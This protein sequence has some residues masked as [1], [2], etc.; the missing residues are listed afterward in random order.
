MSP[1]GYEVVRVSDLEAL[2][3]VNGP[4]FRPLRRRLGIA[5]FGANCWTGENAGDPVIERHREPDGP[6]ELY[7]VLQGRATFTLGD[8]TIDAPVGTI[9]SAPPGTLREAVA[10]EPA[11]TVLA[12]GGTE[13]VAYRPLA[14]EDFYVASGYQRLGREERGRAVIR[15]MLAAHPDGWQEH[16]N[17]ACFEAIAGDAD[18]ALAHLRRAAILDRDAVRKHAATDCDFDALRSDP[19]FDEA[20]S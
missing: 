17:A 9:V 15:E 6:E 12:V 16:Y 2:P 20:L 11:T 3:N 8:E 19:L 4:V 5:A 18:A 14:W 7:V 1:R 13:G 10:A